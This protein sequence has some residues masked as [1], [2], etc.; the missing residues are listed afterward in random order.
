MR[1]NG[2]GELTADD[3]AMFAHLGIEPQLLE[4]AGIKR[5]TDR[6]ARDNYGIV[7]HGSMSGIVFPYFE[8][9]KGNASRWTARLRR[10]KPDI[11]DG[12]PKRKY[13]TPY[14]DRPH[15]F[16]PRGSD[17]L[18]A[19]TT[20]PVILVEAEKSALALL[21][22]S[23][24]VGQKLAPVA[25][26]GCWGWKGRVGKVETARGE[27]VDEYGALADLSVCRSGRCTYILL[28]ANCTTNREVQIARRELVKA[29]R[30]QQADVQI[31]DLPAGDGVNG[32]DD[33]IGVMGDQAMARLFEGASAGAKIL[34]DVEEFL[35]RFVILSSA[36]SAAIALWV[37]HTY[38][39]KSATW[40]PYLNVTS[41]A[42]ECGKS[43]L[44][45]VLELL[46]RKP[47]KVDGASPAVL[48]R[49]IEI[50]QPTMLFDELDT[51]FKGDKE[52]AQ[53]IR[54]VLNAGAKYNGVVA[55]CVGEHHTPKDFRVF[56]PKV[57]AGIGNLPATVS[58]RSLPISL[59]RRLPKENVDYLDHDDPDIVYNAANLRRRLSD[60]IEKRT[61]R[62]NQPPDFPESLT[63]RQKDG[64]RIL[65]A[66]ADA[67]GGNW[68]SRSRA[69]LCELNGSRPGEDVSVGIQLL[70][71]LRMV[72]GEFT[73]KVTTI[74]IL[75]D[76]VE[77]ET[78][79]WAEWNRG[80]P[81]TAVGLSRLLKAF[82]I[83]PKNIRMATGVPKGYERSQFE[84]AWDRY[85]P[86]TS[87]SAPFPILPAATPL[88][89]NI[90][91][92]T[93]H[94]SETL[95]G[96]PVAGSKSQES[97]IKTRAVAD[98]APRDALGGKRAAIL[99]CPVHG[100]H[101]SWW[102]RL[103]LGG[104]M[105]CEMCHPDPLKTVAVAT[106]E[107]GAPGAGM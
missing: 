6:Q 94:F 95:H 45:E 15:L 102:V 70:R 62:F 82:R 18:L 10:D 89:A 79:P 33:Y 28:D 55:R 80:K 99:P 17:E 91:A 69:V 14:G 24:R 107:T 22:W 84:D 2:S 75:Q 64:S 37:A 46:V 39:F 30:K 43:L 25:L 44:L 59:S 104:E 97:P 21:A 56:C 54:Q 12:K 3:L 87:P 93:D 65:L 100:V 9:L 20:V 34:D 7:G 36:Q 74:D 5:V 35:R 27:R 105:V 67:A 96:E 11:E 85:L 47:W 72:F 8:P 92:G 52:T 23:E 32:P 51:T 49:K 57:L 40:T 53:A 38:T 66:I 1:T 78:S 83:F 98:V 58:S 61:V 16:F 73:A 19:D 71:D 86:K 42:P 41:A 90:H 106:S 29:L 76:L 88:Q 81:I 4:R 103:E 31:L 48:F 13:M 101:D 50:D 26:G 63:D 77:I 68:P 60:W